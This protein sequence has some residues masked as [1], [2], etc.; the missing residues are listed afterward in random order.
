MLEERLQ[1]VLNELREVALDA[2]KADRGNKA[3]S[4]RVRVALQDVKRTLQEI[5]QLSFKVSGD[6]ETVEG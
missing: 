2:Q 1:T 4:R 6:E 5:R 3:A